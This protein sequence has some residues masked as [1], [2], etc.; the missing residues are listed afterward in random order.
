MH[1]ILPHETQHSRIWLRKQAGIF[2]PESVQCHTF[3]YQVTSIA[4]RGALITQT[5]VPRNMSPLSNIAGEAMT[6]SSKSQKITHR[7][8]RNRQKGRLTNGLGHPAGTS[9]P[10]DI[11]NININMKLRRKH[12]S[13]FGRKYPSKEM[14]SSSAGRFDCANPFHSAS[15]AAVRQRNIKQPCRAEARR[16]PRLAWRVCG[17]S[18]PAFAT[19]AATASFPAGPVVVPNRPAAS[20]RLDLQQSICLQAGRD[21]AT[22]L[23]RTRLPGCI[24]A[25]QGALRGLQHITFK[26][27]VHI[28]SA[29]QLYK[30]P[31]WPR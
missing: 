19:F 23:G 18:T 15:P 20:L 1:V 4:Y 16:R 24:Q 21:L 6:S 26:F 17:G 25:Y 2:H 11:C 10:S 27:S 29:T 28:R 9:K 7:S 14:R 12:F 5:L 31:L 3:K 8:G 30:R 13:T 22:A